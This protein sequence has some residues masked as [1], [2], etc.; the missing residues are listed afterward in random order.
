MTCV[1]GDCDQWASV[2]ELDPER[3]ERIHGYELTQ[4]HT[5]K[6]NESVLEQAG[7]GRL[8]PILDEE[9]D[10][11]KRWRQQA[12]ERIYSGTILINGSWELPAGAFKECGGPS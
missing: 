7:R 8:H 5:I 4:R 11:V 3:F 1:F 12:M 2:R 9:N 10:N 6:R